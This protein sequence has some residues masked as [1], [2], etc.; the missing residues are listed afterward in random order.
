MLRLLCH[1]DWNQN[2][3]VFFK[4]IQTSCCIHAFLI[5]FEFAKANFSCG[6]RCDIIRT[7]E[8]LSLDV[9]KNYA[10]DATS[11]IV[12]DSFLVTKEITFFIMK[13]EVGKIQIERRLL[14]LKIPSAVTHLHMQDDHIVLL[15]AKTLDKVLHV[16]KAI[17]RRRLQYLAAF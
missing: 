7:L 8:L 6:F 10:Y 3:A 11:Y 16:R 4:C 1:V 9:A 12:N 13:S 15:K 2:C 14:R 5:Y 17:H